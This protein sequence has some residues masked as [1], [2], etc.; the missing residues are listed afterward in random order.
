MSPGEAGAFGC[1]VN[2]LQ[3]RTSVIAPRAS[4]NGVQLYLRKG[5]MIPLEFAIVNCKPVAVVL[6]PYLGQFE[7]SHAKGRPVIM[8]TTSNDQLNCTILQKPLGG[9]YVHKLPE[10][11]QGISHH[12]LSP[13]AEC[14]IL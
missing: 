6:L 3:A 14:R 11:I 4:H 8:Y 2:W 7:G 5:A 1:L 10:N 9:T 13:R 12:R